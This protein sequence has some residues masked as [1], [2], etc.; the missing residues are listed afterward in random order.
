MNIELIPVLSDNY[1]YA[2]HTD[3]GKAAI[4]DPGEAAPVIDFFR[5]NDLTLTHILLTHHHHDHI[6]G[7]MTVK[8]QYGAEILGPASDAH[9]IDGMTQTLKDGDHININGHSCEIL[10]V[11]GHTSGH[12]AFYFPD[13]G[14]LFCGDTLFSMGCGRLFEGTPEEM[15]GSLSKIMALPKKTMIYCGHEYT[16]KNGE[17]CLTIE[18]ENNALQAR[19][20][21]VK[22]L[23]AQNRPTIPVSLETELQTNC[24]LRAGSAEEFARIRKLKDAA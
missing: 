2:L 16:Q 9:R 19:M 12:I 17:F 22:S 4:I 21:E 7:A 1:C 23:R 15:W 8:Q 11:P 14:A 3:S 18:P 6:G 10:S 13:D 20:Q 5:N 24:F